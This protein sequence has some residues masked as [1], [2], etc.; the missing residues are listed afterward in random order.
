MTIFEEEEDLYFLYP[1][2]QSVV[3]RAKLL[4]TKC[5]YK[6]KNLLFANI[7]NSVLARQLYNTDSFD[8]IL[9]YTDCYVLRN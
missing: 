8:V 3:T 6:S 1:K 7:E 9:D 2:L 4:F 5:S